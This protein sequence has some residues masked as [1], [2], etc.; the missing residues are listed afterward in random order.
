MNQTAA[1]YEPPKKISNYSQPDK[2]RILSLTPSEKVKY[3]DSI[4]ISYPKLQEM[5]SLVEDCHNSLKTQARPTCMRVSGKPGTG[6]TNLHE[7]YSKKYPVINEITG[8]FKPVLYSRIPCPAYI[9]GLPPQL[10]Y[11]LGDPFYN[12]S[13]KIVLQTKRLYNLL[14]ECKVKIIFLDEVQHLV[15]RNSQKLLRDSSDW[16]KE[17][18]DETGIPIIFLGMPDSDKIFIENEQLSDRVRFVQST[19]EFENDDIFRKFLY[20]YDMALPLEESSS[21]ADS[22]MCSRLFNSTKGKIRNIHNLLV[23]SVSIAIANNTT[24]ITMPMFARAHNKILYSESVK[25]PFI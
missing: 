12:K 23:E 6:K 19:K 7:I 20:L 18:I 21:L 4:R 16:F 24:R 15:D 25:N 8:T 9:G 2:S 3:T 11:D 13:N 14:K 5:L 10:L 1:N 17:L 22:D